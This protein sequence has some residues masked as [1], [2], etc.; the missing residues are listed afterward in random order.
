VN[1][2]WNQLLHDVRVTRDLPPP[3]EARRIRERAGVS[4]LRLAQ[5]LAVHR[6]T[7]SRW[8][9]GVSTPRLSV[10]GPYAQ[11]LASMPAEWAR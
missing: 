6:S 8:E 7:V 11:A 1:S 9:R 4:T 10:R 2:D 3:A 5:A